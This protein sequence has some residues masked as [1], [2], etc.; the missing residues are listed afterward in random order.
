MV[1]NAQIS[2]TMFI[3]PGRERTR[4]ACFDRRPHFISIANGSN[5]FVLALA[6]YLWLFPRLF[7]P[8]VRAFL[9]VDK[10]LSIKEATEEEDGNGHS[11]EAPEPV[12]ELLASC[13]ILYISCVFKYRHE[14]A[15]SS[16]KGSQAMS[17]IMQSGVAKNCFVYHFCTGAGTKLVLWR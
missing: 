8:D 17:L 16:V 4:G 6:F 15:S 9:N 3:W 7:S 12:C 13:S 14:R 1:V 10:N 5:L 2:V 11:T